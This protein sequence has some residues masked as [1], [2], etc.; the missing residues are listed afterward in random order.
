MSM[1]RRS[2]TRAAIYSIIAP[3][4]SQR[5]LGLRDEPP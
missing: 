5:P 1:I 4:N 2:Y 3:G